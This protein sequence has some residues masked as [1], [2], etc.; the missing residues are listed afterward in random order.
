MARVLVA[1]ALS[2]LGRDALKFVMALALAIMLAFHLRVVFGEEPRAAAGRRSGA[3][4]RA[5]GTRTS[6]S[7]RCFERS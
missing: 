6:S 5:C 7:A 1:L 2:D 4:T 3:S